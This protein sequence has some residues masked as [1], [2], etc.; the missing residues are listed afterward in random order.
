MCTLFTIDLYSANS[1]SSSKITN[2]NAGPSLMILV[3]DITCLVLYW[4]KKASIYNF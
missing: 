1:N 4:S 3:L 2:Y